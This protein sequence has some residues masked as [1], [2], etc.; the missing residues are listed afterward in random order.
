MPLIEVLTAVDWSSPALRPAKMPQS[1]ESSS[2]RDSAAQGHALDL[3]SQVSEL[4]RLVAALYTQQ[5]ET[6]EQIED[7]NNKII[8][9]ESQ[10]AT[11]QAKQAAHIST[12]HELREHN[13]YTAKLLSEANANLEDLKK[14]N[15]E[16]KNE[17]DNLDQSFTTAVGKLSLEK[18]KNVS[19]RD[20]LADKKIEATDMQEEKWHVEERLQEL[21]KEKESQAVMLRAS[22]DRLSQEQIARDRLQRG[23]NRLESSVCALERYLAEEAEKNKL[24]QTIILRQRSTIKELKQT[25]CELQDLNISGAGDPGMID[26]DRLRLE[27]GDEKLNDAVSTSKSVAVCSG[28]RSREGQTCRCTAN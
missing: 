3:R 27:V 18:D 10:A 19:L 8:K 13:A 28:W 14:V 26:S 25:V 20:V 17:N 21:N 9:L 5:Q 23:N 15:Q 12:I 1:V 4:L 24:A 22:I 2:S 7:A 16:L 11:Y 6:Q